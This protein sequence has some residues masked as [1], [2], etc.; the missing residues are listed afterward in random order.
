MHQGRLPGPA[1]PHHRGELALGDVEADVVQRG[2]ARL[3]GAVGL[4]QPH[5]PRRHLGCVH[6]TSLPIVVEVRGRPG[7]SLDSNICSILTYSVAM[8]FQSSLFDGAV[9]TTPGARSL[10][11]AER[12]TLTRGAWVDVPAQLRRRRRRR[13]RAS[14]RR[15][16]VARRAPADVRPGGRRARASCTP[17]SSARSC[18]TRCSR[19]PATLSRRTTCPSS[20]SRSSPRG[21]ASTVTAATRRLARRH[22]RPRPARPTRWSR[23][24]PSATRDGWAPAAGRRATRSGSEMGHGDL[25]VMGGSCQRTWEHAIP[26]SPHAGPRISVQFRPLNVF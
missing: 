18:P 6:A 12:T 22:D 20:A 23:S 25:V 16:P 15:R 10:D 9:A 3:A 24:S 11:G 7:P 4:G 26:R 13:A 17:T 2:D 14:G 8:D 5:D 21:A 19:R 1:R